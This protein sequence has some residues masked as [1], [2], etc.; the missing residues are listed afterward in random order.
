MDRNTKKEFIQFQDYIGKMYPEFHTGS[1]ECNDGNSEG[2]SDSDRVLSRD[3]TFQVTDACNLACTYCYQTNKG[4]R[5][6]SLETAKL[7]VDKLLSGVDGFGE[8]IDVKKSPAIVLDFIGGEPFIEIE[9]IDKIV[10]Y[11]RMRAIELE[12][13]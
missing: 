9:L 13:P 12:H 10:D 5:R 6:M 3:F 7:A 1:V 4:T 2:G 11:F 8:Y